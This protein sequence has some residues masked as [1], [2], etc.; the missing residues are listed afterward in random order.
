MVD[1]KQIIRRKH[2]QAKRLKLAIKQQQVFLTT[3]PTTTEWQI[4]Q[5]IQRSMPWLEQHWPTKSTQLCGTVIHLAA[6]NKTLTV[7]VDAQCRIAMEVGNQLHLPA[8]HG[9]TNQHL[10]KWLIS[11]AKLYLPNRL[12]L[13]A[14]S[15]ALPYQ[16]CTIKRT[17]GRWGSCN[18][19]KDISLNALLLLLP[20]PQIDYVLIHELCHTVH[21]NHSAAYWQLVSRYCSDYLLQRK[22]VKAFAMP[23][24]WTQ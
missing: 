7:V 21:M 11:Q 12:Q 13:L 23:A 10:Q 20:Q 4:Q 22:A 5:F 6:I 16:S 24:W 9:S 14:Q 8:N 3:P 2:P 19:H 18:A 1:L 15:Y 17:V